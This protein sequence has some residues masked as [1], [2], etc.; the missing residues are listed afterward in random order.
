MRKYLRVSILI[1]NPKSWF[2]QFN[3]DLFTLI[4]TY[5][6]R[7]SFVR[8]SRNLRR[9]D[10]LFILSCN[11]ILGKKQ[12]SLHKSNIVVHASDLPKGRGWSPWTWQVE[13]GR[14]TIPLTL[15]EAAGDV[16]TG[17]YYLK[18]TI[19]LQGSELVDE[20]RKKL[21][22][23][24]IKMIEKYLKLYPMAAKP[25]KGRPSYFRKR[26]REDYE[27]NLNKSIK[28]QFHKMRVADNERYP[29]YFKYR[30]KEYI[31]MVYQG[32]D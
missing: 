12:L 16:D 3:S 8:S 27:L 15:F 24:I 22:K 1:D 29:L 2:N 21:A 30:G 32:R 4:K 25:Q 11:H 9:G 26:K 18:D 5:D 23:K 14:K 6:P 13:A 19:M 7:F 31:L 17:G 10:I 28:S 20:I